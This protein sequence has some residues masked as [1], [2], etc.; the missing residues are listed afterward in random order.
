MFRY[1]PEVDALALRLIDRKI[2]D[3]HELEPGILIDLDVDGNIVGLEILDLQERIDDTR[4]VRKP[5]RTATATEA[6]A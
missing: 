5:E 4:S 6:A 2:A 1:D 3:T